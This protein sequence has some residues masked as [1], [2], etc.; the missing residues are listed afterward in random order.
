MKEAYF[1]GDEIDI[2]QIFKIYNKTLLAA[3]KLFFLG[4]DCI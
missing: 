2:F 4:N 3:N 1:P